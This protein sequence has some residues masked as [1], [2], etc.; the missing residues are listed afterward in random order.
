MW[1]ILKFAESSVLMLSSTLF[2]VGVQCEVEPQASLNALED[3]VNEVLPLP[4]KD[5]KNES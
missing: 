1:D 3:K 5:E 4:S 2:Q